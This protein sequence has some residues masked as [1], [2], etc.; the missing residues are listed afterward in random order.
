MV[1]FDAQRC[2]CPAREETL[3]RSNLLSAVRYGSARRV[4]AKAMPRKR[5]RSQNRPLA[6]G[7][8]SSREPK[9]GRLERTSTHLSPTDC[10]RHPAKR[11]SPSANLRSRLNLR[12]ASPRH[13]SSAY[14]PE[15]LRSYQVRSESG[16]TR[17]SR[18]NSS[19][20]S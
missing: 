3:T 11:R 6:S 16:F 10:S 7:L 15:S 13:G 18:K 14:R 2:L 4:L 12:K 5:D 8:S 17:E 1:Q 9:V 19:T 20:R